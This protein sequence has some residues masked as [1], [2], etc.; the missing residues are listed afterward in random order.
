VI[1][2]GEKGMRSGGVERRQS[3]VARLLGGR[4]GTGI[5]EVEN[6][7]PLLDVFFSPSIVVYLI[8]KYFN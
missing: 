3:A 1:G 2:V 5:V 4:S 6:T 8:I 7:F